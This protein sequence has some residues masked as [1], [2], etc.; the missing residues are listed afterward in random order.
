[1]KHWIYLLFA[2]AAE[3]VG[4]TALRVSDGFR[5]PLPSLLVVAGYGLSFYLLSL[6]LRA[7]PVSL[8]Y[9]IWSGVGLLL[10]TLVGWVYFKQRL[11]PPA[12]IGMALII[13]GVLVMN[14]FSKSVPH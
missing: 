2:I 11:D 6:T 4:T 10:I 12:I 14:L 13:V 7:F 3:V 1:M 8:A 9:A 5:K